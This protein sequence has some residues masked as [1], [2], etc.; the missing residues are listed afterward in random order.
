VQLFREFVPLS[1]SCQRFLR[2]SSVSRQPGIRKVDME[3]L[4]LMD[5]QPVNVKILW[6]LGIMLH[7]GEL[8]ILQESHKLVIVPQRQCQCLKGCC[9]CCFAHLY[10]VQPP[11]D[12][13]NPIII[14]TPFE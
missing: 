6:R 12:T 8:S 13:F 5:G 14:D 3:L 4:R 11:S 9:Q 1:V 10:I 2:N 7:H